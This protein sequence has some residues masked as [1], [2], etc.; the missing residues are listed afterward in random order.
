MG[1]F[2][3]DA[4]V[5]VAKIVSTAKNAHI[6]FLNIYLF[7]SFVNCQIFHWCLGYFTFWN[8]CNKAIIYPQFIF[9]CWSMN[10]VSGVWSNFD[11][12]VNVVN[13][14]ISSRLK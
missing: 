5:T 6:N 2:A 14:R 8:D 7:P 10:E 9:S 4:V 11:V 12:P 3:A 13:R 1:D